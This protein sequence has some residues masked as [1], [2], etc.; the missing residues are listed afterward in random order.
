MKLKFLASA[1]GKLLPFAILQIVL[2]KTKQPEKNSLKYLYT[3]FLNSVFC[4]IFL[5]MLR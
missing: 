4:L 2:V 5:S 1:Y 3:M